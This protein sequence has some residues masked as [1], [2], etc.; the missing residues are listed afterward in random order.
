M[1]FLTLGWGRQDAIGLLDRFGQQ[2]DLAALP[3]DATWNAGDYLDG[4]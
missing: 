4:G 2:V 1:G 3:A